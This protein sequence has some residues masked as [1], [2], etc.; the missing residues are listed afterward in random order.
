VHFRALLKLR[1]TRPNDFLEYA[2]ETYIKPALAAETALQHSSS[3]SSSSDRSS[4]ALDTARRRALDLGCGNGR[5]T[6]YMAQVLADVTYSRHNV[7]YMIVI[8]QAYHSSTASGVSKFS[9]YTRSELA[10][11]PACTVLDSAAKECV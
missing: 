6:V 4:N 7:H 5:D 9:P 2:I 11:T 10:K 3:D 1:T 8:T